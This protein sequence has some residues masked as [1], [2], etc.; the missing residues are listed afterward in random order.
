MELNSVFPI[1]I[2]LYIEKYKTKFEFHDRLLKA[3][4]HLTTYFIR[5]PIYYEQNDSWECFI[6]SFSS[7]NSTPI[8]RINEYK[9]EDGKIITCSAVTITQSRRTIKIKKTKSVAGMVTIVTII[10]IVS[11]GSKTFDY[12]YLNAKDVIR[13]MYYLTMAFTFIIG[14]CGFCN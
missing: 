11:T 5:S 4:N 14:F 10:Y 7:I 2:C 12:Q 3:Q 9:T 1:E 13:D 6:D 8:S